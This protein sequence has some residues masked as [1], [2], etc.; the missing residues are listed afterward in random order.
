MPVV[1]I[2]V[3]SERPLTGSHHGTL[4]YSGRARDP[5][6]I[7]VRRDQLIGVLDPIA[8]AFFARVR[9]DPMEI[10]KSAIK[11]CQCSMGSGDMTL[12][13]RLSGNSR[14]GKQASTAYA[15]YAVICKS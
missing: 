13:W 1:E 10:S 7:P 3:S 15:S 14:C 4:D 9:N 2:P 8:A 12:S 11:Q 6:E 5:R